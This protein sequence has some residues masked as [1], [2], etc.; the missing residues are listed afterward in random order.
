MPR[1]EVR[2]RVLFPWGLSTSFLRHSLDHESSDSTAL[3]LT[4]PRTTASN[5]SSMLSTLEVVK[6]VSDHIPQLSFAL[7]L[8]FHAA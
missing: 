5:N 4:M 2:S 1:L 3:P 6:Q 7:R 8:F